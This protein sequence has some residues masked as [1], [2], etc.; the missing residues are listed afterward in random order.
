MNLEE[1][2]HLAASRVYNRINVADADGNQ[3]SVTCWKYAGRSA[4]RDDV[5]SPTDAFTTNATTTRYTPR[6]ALAVGPP[7]AMAFPRS[8]VFT[9]LYCVCYIHCLHERMSD[10]QLKYILR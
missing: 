2:L 6:S 4:C 1:E 5:P 7:T 3:S 10:V 9:I 8:H